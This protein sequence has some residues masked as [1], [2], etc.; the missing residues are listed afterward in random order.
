MA[1]DS[2]LAPIIMK[3][4]KIV[5]GDGHHGGAWKVAY[6]DFVTAMMAFFLLMWLLNATTEKQRK[7]IADYFSPTI[8]IARMS[9]GGDGAFGGS[10]VFS[11]EVLPRIGTGATS[12]RPTSQ[13]AARGSQSN[14]QNDE[15]RAKDEETYEIIEELLLG[16][17][18]ESDL[19]DDTFKHIV[20]RVTDEGVILE[21][22]ATE[23]NRLFD[24]DSKPTAMMEEFAT[25]VRNSAEL[26]TNPIAIETYVSSFPLVLADNPAWDIS[27]ARGSALRDLFAKKG[28]SQDRIQRVTSY[29]D[30]DPN[31]DNPMHVRNNRVKIVFLR[32]I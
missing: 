9:G 20:T 6:A 30:R 2:N 15:G 27:S 24:A 11:E 16:R 22:F 19:S 1:E 32:E 14:A 3:K 8:A 10:S 31:Q 5:A 12:L 23:Q 28:F 4:K 18:G 21:I 13:D 29:A 17:G 25:L 26:V 7:G